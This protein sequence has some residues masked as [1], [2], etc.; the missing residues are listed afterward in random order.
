M[1]HPSL[2]CLCFT[3]FGMMGE[4]K[5]NLRDGLIEASIHLVNREYDALAADFVT[6]GYKLDLDLH[7]LLGSDNSL[8]WKEFT[9]SRSLYN[10]IFELLLAYILFANV[11]RLLPPTAEMGEL[12]KA[13]TGMTWQPYICLPRDFL[14]WWISTFI[15]H[16]TC[17]RDRTLLVSN[18]YL[19][20]CLVIFQV[21]FRR[22]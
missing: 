8:F 17:V 2:V 12:S 1:W 21:C 6:L 7:K 4:M 22:L 18:K 11:H 15:S 19:I 13:L 20:L 3:D 16:L 5:E 10:W 14:C 9:R